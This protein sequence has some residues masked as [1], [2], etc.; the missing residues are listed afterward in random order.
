MT[1]K[2][3][4][5]WIKCVYL[6]YFGKIEISRLSG[7]L[8]RKICIELQ[9][10]EYNTIIR[11]ERKTMDQAKQIK[12]F[13]LVAFLWIGIFGALSHFFYQWS[14]YKKLVGILFPANESTWEHLKF[15]IVPTVLY[16]L[17]GSLLIKN[18]NYMV[19]FSLTL[20]IPMILIPIIFYTY[21]FFT[22]HSILLLDILTYYVSILI[23]CLVCG[24]VLM[25]NPF[26]K[27]ISI[28]SEIMFVC[29]MLCYLLFTRYPPKF[30]LFRDAVTG[31][32]G[33]TNSV[34]VDHTT[35]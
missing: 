7:Y 8:C 32:Y 5:F 9:H 1:I 17:V 12:L 10:D 18:A 14:G 15:A 34:I 25:H 19:A 35:P 13:C 2:N 31:G 29:I 4:S 27:V 21:T 11:V 28:I 6:V 24:M 20:L 30:F 26:P 16:F 23:A 22:G 3:R 33:L